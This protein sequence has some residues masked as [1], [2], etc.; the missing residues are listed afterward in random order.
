[1]DITERARLY[2][3]QEENKKRRKQSYRNKKKP[4]DSWKEIQKELSEEEIKTVLELSNE[5]GRDVSY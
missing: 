2:A 1:M 3:E 5:F 4:E